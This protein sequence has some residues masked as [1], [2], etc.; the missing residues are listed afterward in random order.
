MSP[1]LAR[2]RNASSVPTGTGLFPVLPAA[3]DI[4]RALNVSASPFVHS[5][6]QQ[7]CLSRSPPATDFSHGLL[8]ATGHL[9][10][11][12]S[13]PAPPP[14]YSSRRFSMLGCMSSLCISGVNP[15]QRHHL[16]TSPP[17]QEVV[18]RS[19]GG[20]LCCGTL[21]SSAESVCLVLPL[22]PWPK[23]T[24]YAEGYRCEGTKQL[25][26]GCYLVTRVLFST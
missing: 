16:Q 24:A 25:L 11:L 1:K 17:T 8:V 6:T 4:P 26:L 15:N 5:T 19:I 20:F 21:F 7:A 10:T 9:H 14:C 13:L 22:L 12:F 2:L 3:T 18:L 23:E